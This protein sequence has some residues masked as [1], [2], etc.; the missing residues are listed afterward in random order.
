MA[1]EV[2]KGLRMVGRM[3]RRLEEQAETWTEKLFP[4][5][6]P[7]TSC[8]KINKTPPNPP[9][10]MVVVVVVVVVSHGLRNLP[11][12]SPGIGRLLAVY[13][14]ATAAGTECNRVGA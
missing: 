3:H 5:R 11:F 10:H 4:L 12:L 6:G 2:G 8:I 1:V 14:S 9:N 7:L 13:S